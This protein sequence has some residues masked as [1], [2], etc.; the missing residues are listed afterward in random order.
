MS[1]TEDSGNDSE[2]ERGL[3]GGGR[4]VIATFNNFTFSNLELHGTRL[5]EGVFHPSSPPKKIAAGASVTWKG[6]SSWLLGGTEGNVWYKPENDST[7]F[8][9]YW[10]NPTIGAN[11]YG[12]AVRSPTSD[13][14][15]M[16]HAGTSGGTS[17]ASYSV[18]EKS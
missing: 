6:E 2:I 12:S 8:E 15:S 16:V 13:I 3:G 17:R 9:T 4:G 14:Y 7:K 10:N 1:N 11:S 5:L 18:Y